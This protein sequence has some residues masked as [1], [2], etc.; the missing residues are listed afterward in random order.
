M[1]NHLP[2]IKHN[3]AKNKCNPAYLPFA[4]VLMDDKNK[5]NFDLVSDNFDSCVKNI[6]T[7]ITGDAV[8]PIYYASNVISNAMHEMT[9]GVTAIR[10]TFNNVRVDIKDTAENISGRTLNITIPILKFYNFG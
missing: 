8:E 3:W 2:T 7:T 9:K 6:L 10:A 4:G 1:L 5:S